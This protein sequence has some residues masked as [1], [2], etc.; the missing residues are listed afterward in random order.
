MATHRSSPKDISAEILCSSCTD[1]MEASTGAGSSGSFQK[2]KGEMSKEGHVFDEIGQ[3]K[4]YEAQ[5][6]AAEEQDARR[7]QQK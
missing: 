4:F 7:S 2:I 6:F 1:N 5:L 3:M